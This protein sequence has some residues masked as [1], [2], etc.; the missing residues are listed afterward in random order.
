MLDA[1]AGVAPAK[2]AYETGRILN[3][4][5]MNAGY[6][7]RR[8]YSLRRVVSSEGIEP[9]ASSVSWRCSTAE[10]T[11][12]PRGLRPRWLPQIYSFQVVQ[13]KTRSFG[14]RV[15]RGSG[16]GTLAYANLGAGMWLARSLPKVPTTRVS[17]HCGIAA[18]VCQLAF[19]VVGEFLMARWCHKS[20]GPGSPAPSG[21]GCR[22]RHPRVPRH[23]RKPTRKMSSASY[24]LLLGFG[25]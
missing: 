24:G 15:R 4:S 1:E 17:W 10:L 20:P 14:L 19:R 21:G 8:T 7:R 6:C 5:A 12:H 25:S 3:L 9:P 16:L 23:T 18:A 13:K 2:L 11:G 22:G